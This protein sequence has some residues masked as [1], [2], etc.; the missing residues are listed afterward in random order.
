MRPFEKRLG[1]R[2]LSFKDPDSASRVEQS[3]RWNN[4]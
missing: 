4:L 1:V 2:I 3:P